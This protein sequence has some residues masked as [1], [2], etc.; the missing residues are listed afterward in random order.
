MSNIHGGIKLVDFASC[1]PVEHLAVAVQGVLNTMFSKLVVLSSLAVLAV[2]TPVPNDEPASSCTTGPVQCCQ[3]TTT[4][5]AP[6][7]ASILGLLGV[8][9]QDLNIPVGLTCTPISVRIPLIFIESN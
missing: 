7:A 9:V 1:S 5:G 4:A 8:V 2:A 6:A 3:S